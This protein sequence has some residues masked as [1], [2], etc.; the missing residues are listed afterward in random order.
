MQQAMPV[1]P[2]PGIL[3]PV[4]MPTATPNQIPPQATPIMPAANQHAVPV[5]GPSPAALVTP[6]GGESANSCSTTGESLAVTDLNMANTKEKTPMCLINE[7]ARYNKVSSFPCT[8]IHI[9]LI[10]KLKSKS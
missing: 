8:T 10:T 7:L 3:Q 4:P 6:S 1:G 9:V 2:V 5:A